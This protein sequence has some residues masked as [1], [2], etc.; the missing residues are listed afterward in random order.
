MKL[1]N[2][3]LNTTLFATSLLSATFL[4]AQEIENTG[5]IYLGGVGYF[6]DSD[7]NIDDDIGFVIGGEL[8]VSE[9]W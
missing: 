1:R 9:R 8:P 2:V 7:R 4:Q 5:N 3:L 6:S